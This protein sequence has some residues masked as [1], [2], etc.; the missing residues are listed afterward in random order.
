MRSREASNSDRNDIVYSSAQLLNTSNTHCLPQC[1]SW[2]LKGVSKIISQRVVLDQG[3]HD[4]S[5]VDLERGAWKLQSNHR[6]V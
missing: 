6:A 2:K 5:E 1:I 4:Q 3:I